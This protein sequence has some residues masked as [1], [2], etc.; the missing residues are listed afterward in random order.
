MI[1]LIDGVT[2]YPE[3]Q[4][5]LALDTATIFEEKN[6]QPVQFDKYKV[7]PWG[8]DNNLPIQVLE[9]VK[10]SEVISSNLTFNRN[11]C[12]GLGPKLVKLIRDKS[13]KVVDFLEVE[14]G[15]ELDF[16]ERNDI[17]L[18]FSEQLTD[19][20]YFHNAFVELIPDAKKD[21][22]YSIRHKEA[23]FSRWSTMN[24]KGK[25][26]YHF[27]CGDWQGTVDK[28]T[29]MVSKALDEFDTLTDIST[30]M[31]IRK[32]R[33]IYPVYMPSPGRPY[34]SLPEWYSIFESGWYDH[35]VAIPALK[36]AILKNN[37]GVKF[38]IYISAEYF[39][40]IYKKEGIDQTDQKAVKERIEK[41]KTRFNE[42]L[43]GTQNANKSLLTIKGF[44]QSG[45]TAIENKWIEIIPI[46]NN[47]EG[48]EYITDTETAANIICYAMNVHPSLIGATPGKSSGSM[49]GTD[50]REL[51]LMKQ[52]LM[53]PIIDRATRIF[54]LIKK[55]NDWP[56]DI[57]IVV[58]EYQFTTL[59]KNK[60]GKQEIINN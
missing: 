16:F 51:F 15:A 26:D 38:I 34:Y 7:A 58:P 10:K 27:Y 60:T 30:K 23:A 56:A 44:I 9:K 17:P 14:S 2:F 52:A 40:D 22:I 39:Q 43:A 48:G 55:I 46:K 28:N 57:T 53:K 45:N 4:A 8:L 1:E 21:S 37:L 24:N 5:V 33:M 25:I 32:E 50:K 54:R 59:D 11:V 13:L 49:S 29:A 36:K 47:L 6:I 41:E 3:I 18:F 35:S 19:L 12:Y 42:F 31:K 20:N